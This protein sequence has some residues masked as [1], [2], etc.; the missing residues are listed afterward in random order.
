VTNQVTIHETVLLTISVMV[1][2]A[3]SDMAMAITGISVFVGVLLLCHLNYQKQKL[4]RT[5]QQ[6]EALFQEGEFPKRIRVHEA[7]D[8]TTVFEIRHLND[9]KGKP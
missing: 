4:A 8:P 9:T 1:L 3:I 2:A 5:V 7:P 6:Y